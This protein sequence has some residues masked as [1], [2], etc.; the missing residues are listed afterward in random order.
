V[1]NPGCFATAAELLLLP[2]ARRGFCSGNDACFRRHRLVGAG[3]LP[4]ATTHHPFRAN[5]FFAIKCWRT[6]TSRKSTKPSPTPGGSTA[7]DQAAGS[8]R[9][10]VARHPRR[11]YLADE[12]FAATDVA[13]AIP[14]ELR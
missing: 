7:P 2:L 11:R 1:A 6:N 10:F 5:N 4:K 9:P 12:A 14:R 8:F 3:A 13:R